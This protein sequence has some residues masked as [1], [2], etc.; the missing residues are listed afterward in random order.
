MTP[1]FPNIRSLRTCRGGSLAELAVDTTVIL[2]AGS[3]LHD[4]R[5]LAETIAASNPRLSALV[6]DEATH[7]TMPMSPAAVLNTALLQALSEA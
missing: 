6:V 1:T 4:S 7:H 5:R 3:K 2:A